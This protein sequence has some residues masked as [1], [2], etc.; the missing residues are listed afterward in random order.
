MEP[1]QEE[2]YSLVKEEC[3][4]DKTPLKAELLPPQYRWSCSTLSQRICTQLI[5]SV[6]PYFLQSVNFS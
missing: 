1:P 2:F 4:G 3:V 6:S 5:S